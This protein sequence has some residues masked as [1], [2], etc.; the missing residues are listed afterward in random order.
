MK[1]FVPSILITSSTSSICFALLSCST[2]RRLFSST[3]LN[4][5]AFYSSHTPAQICFTFFSCLAFF[6]SSA[7]IV[8][9]LPCFYASFSSHIAFVASTVIRLCRRVFC[10]TYS[11]R[12]HPP[13]SPSSLPP[14]IRLLCSCLLHL[15]RLHCT[16]P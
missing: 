7:S 3:F 4:F 15:I 6:A 16:P 9:A 8:S 2:F 13:L 12:P 5:S 10:S 1:I 14:R 11:A